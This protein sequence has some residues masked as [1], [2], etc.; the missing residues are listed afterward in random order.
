MCCY[1]QN[2]MGEWYGTVLLD[3]G[4]QNDRTKNVPT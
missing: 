2:R 4:Y 1:S 3:E